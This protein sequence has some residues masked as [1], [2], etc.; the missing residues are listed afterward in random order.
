MK[1]ILMITLL[2][3]LALLSVVALT[4]YTI[5][6]Q[7]VQQDTRVPTYP[8]AERTQ[9]SAIQALSSFDWIEIGPHTFTRRPL[10]A[11]RRRST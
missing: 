2:L 3:A 6:A 5:E 9:A 7:N 11:H 8:P 1:T 4:T 10:H